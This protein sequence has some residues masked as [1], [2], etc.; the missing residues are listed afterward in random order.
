MAFLHFYDKPFNVGVLAKRLQTAIFSK[1]GPVSGCIVADGIQSC[2]L[3]YKQTP[4]FRTL[5]KDFSELVPETRDIVRDLYQK[6]IFHPN[7]QLND[8]LALKAV[9][10]DPLV[11]E[12]RAISGI[13]EKYIA[14]KRNH[15]TQQDIDVV[16][17]LVRERLKNR[18]I[19]Q[20]FDIV[21]AT[22]GSKP[23]MDSLK[24]RYLS[25]LPVASLATLI[26]QSPVYLFCPPEVFYGYMGLF[27]GSATYLVTAYANG[28]GRLRFVRS[29]FGNIL[30]RKQLVMLNRIVEEYDD[31]FVNVRNYHHSHHL[32][33][34]PALDVQ[35]KRE[36]ARRQFELV[37]LKEHGMY[38][39]YWKTAGDGYIWAEPDQDPAEIKIKP[40]PSPLSPKSLPKST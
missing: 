40:P 29:G 18:Q 24:C 12:F 15:L 23:F 6:L 31:L 20:A 10:E 28:T 16:F 7:V 36:L 9:F 11:L 8:P 22:V 3:L 32:P 33:Y 30:R 27:W 38:Y 14:S 26:I 13:L 35:L 5:P 2:K 25:V 39:D 17:V 19:F 1:S 37:P 34:I 4:G 21:D